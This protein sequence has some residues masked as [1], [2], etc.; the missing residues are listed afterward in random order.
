[1]E[2]IIAQDSYRSGNIGT[3]I[4]S[5]TVDIALSSVAD[6]DSYQFAG[7]GSEIYLMDPDPDPPC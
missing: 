5:D 3:V 4:A 1:M 6:P 7:S 2:V